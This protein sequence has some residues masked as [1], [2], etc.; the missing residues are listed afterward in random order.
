MRRQ[1]R[2]NAG[3][4]PV[5]PQRPQRGPGVAVRP[6]AHRAIAGQGVGTL[7]RCLLCFLPCNSRVRAC[8]GGCVFVSDAIVSVPATPRFRPRTVALQKAYLTLP[9]PKRNKNKFQTNWLVI[10]KSR[11]HPFESLKRGCVGSYRADDKFAKLS[12]MRK[13]AEIFRRQRTSSNDFVSSYHRQNERSRRFAEAR[14]HSHCGW[15]HNHHR[16]ERSRQG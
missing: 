8:V 13:K 14:R 9:P 7:A 1:S 10:L 11:D 5:D 2:R 15:L 16:H 6:G 3:Q 4:G 12:E